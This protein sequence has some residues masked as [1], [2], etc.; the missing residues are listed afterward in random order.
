V[1]MDSQV[2]S[3]NAEHAIREINAAGILVLPGGLTTPAQMQDKELL[4]WVRQIHEK[5]KWTTSVCTGSMILAA[6]G[7]LKG[8]DATTHW[9]AMDAL[10][11]FGAKPTHQRVVQQGKIITAAGVSSGIDMA[12][13][14]V[15]LEA[16]EETAKGIQLTIEYD[17]QPP[18]NS[19]SIEKA[20]PATI[21]KAKA[22]LAESTR[23]AAGTK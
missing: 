21:E 1:R 15:S 9:L 8:L 10:K 11:M 5:S 6:A 22:F 16:G 2:L 4:A 13:K 7:L 17:P 18:F 20:S 14:L 3:L 12:L 19:G 23:K